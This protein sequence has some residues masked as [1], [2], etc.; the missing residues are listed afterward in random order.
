[1]LFNTPVYLI[2]LIVVVGV[3]YLLPKKFDKLFL[4]AASYVFY[5]YWDWRFLFLLV[6][7]SLV[8]FYLGSLIYSAKSQISRKRILWF[9]L[10]L[11]LSVLCFFKYYNFFV[12]SFVIAFE[13]DL[14]FLH[15][16][17]LL[18]V[19]ISFYTF[20]SLSYTFDIYRE[21]LI[22]TKSLLDYC[23]FVGVFPHMIS[24][25]IVKA[26][27]L[28]PQLENLAKPVVSDIRIGF[29]IISVGMFQKVLIGDTVAKHV[30]H[31]FS[32]P[33]YYSSSELLFSLFMFAIQIY[34]DFAGYSNIARGSAKL[35]GI[36]LIDN[37]NQ[38]FFAKNITDFWRRWHISLSDWLKEYVY[39]W[40]LGGNRMG[41]ARTYLNLMITMLLGGIWHGANWTFVVW[42]G[43]HGLALATHKWY[44]SRFKP[45]ENRNWILEFAAGAVSWVS[46]FLLVV[47][48]FLF[49]RSSDFGT[50]WFY[51]NRIFLHTTPGD[52]N[53]SLFEIF[54]TFFAALLLIDYV[55]LKA[56]SH[57][58]LLR[59]QPVVRYG[60][61]LPTWVAILLKMYTVGKPAPFIYFQF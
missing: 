18:P 13:T 48:A 1:M 19:G 16:H 43:L 15:I 29:A 40:W 22:P 23:L 58:F 27:G 35:F 50:A 36:D 4:L 11:N 14:D 57:A 47:F 41:E 55:E 9:S 10:F 17:V 25:P 32:D 24:G 26:K 42:G 38:P 28:L 33:T 6:G 5:G 49:F 52:I 12:D 3:F 37:F 8:D 2:F 45:T 56:Q 44:R 7:S 30:D 51:L 53:W 61:L 46:T 54:V 39:I 34:A 20:Q 60:L 59:L 31:I 21:K